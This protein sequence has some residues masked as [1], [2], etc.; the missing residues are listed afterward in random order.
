LT[1]VAELPAGMVGAFLLGA[2]VVAL[3]AGGPAMVRA[4][5][6]PALEPSP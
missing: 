5:S 3:L 1:L 6:G 4:L 2:P